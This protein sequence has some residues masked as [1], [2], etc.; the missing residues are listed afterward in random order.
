[1]IASD[2]SPVA[3]DEVK[4]AGAL[5]ENSMI[6]I[7]VKLKKGAGQGLIRIEAIAYFCKDDG[8]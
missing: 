3:I 4:A 6:N 2:D 7:P 5:K 1:M 8:P